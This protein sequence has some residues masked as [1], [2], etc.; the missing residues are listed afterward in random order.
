MDYVK[1]EG[2]TAQVTI[3]GRYDLCI[4]P[5]V[6]EEIRS[7]LRSGCTYVLYD[8]TDTYYIDS[9]AVKDMVEIYR[10]DLSRS[11]FHVDNVTGNVKQLFE[12]MNLY[13]L[14]CV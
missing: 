13:Q 9:A 4:T 5:K 11:N 8:M 1:I 2:R 3:K 6:T 12:V 10:D 14:W 7:A